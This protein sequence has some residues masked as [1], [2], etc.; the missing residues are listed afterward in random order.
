MSDY[1]IKMKRSLKERQN[2]IIKIKHINNAMQVLSKYSDRCKE[3]Y[4]QRCVRMQP[5]FNPIHYFSPQLFIEIC[6]IY[7]IR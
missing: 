1:Q 3:K 2:R 6:Y 5:A 4:K 7:F